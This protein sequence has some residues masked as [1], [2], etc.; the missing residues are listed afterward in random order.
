MKSFAYIVNPIT[1][2]QLKDF[3][4]AVK[5]L[6]DF[7]L[8]PAFKNLAPFK[9]AHIKK[10]KSAP[11]QEISGFLILCPLL[12][13]LSAL[14]EEFI[15]EK[16]IYASRIAEKLGVDILGLGGYMALILDES[17]KLAKNLKIPLT[18]GNSYTSWSVFE[19]IY[20]L[21]KARNVALKESKLAIIGAANPMGSLCARKLAGYVNS[22]I[23]FDKQPD[24][25]EPLREAILELNPIEAIIA[26]DAQRAVKDAD[27]VINANSLPGVPFEVK[28]LKPNAVVCDISLSGDILTQGKARPDVTII[29]AGLIRLP[30]ARNLSISSGLP[31]GIVPASLAETML[32][33]FAG[34]FTNYSLLGE[35]V[36]LDKLEDIADLAARHG[37]EVWVP[38]APLQ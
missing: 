10:I 34:K 6:P 25:L 16:I 15:I 19:A 36:N 13:E 9:I 31:K 23:I 27:I 1:I 4:P 17:N 2:K 22:I 18:S 26:E 20:R 38:Q 12:E 7:I 33:T 21:T 24:E 29:Q 5:I 37:F 14:E 8:K 32:L 35:S 3:W 11:G 28:E 30:D